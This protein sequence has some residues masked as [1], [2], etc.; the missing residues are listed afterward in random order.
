MSAGSSSIADF[1]EATRRF[2]RD[3]AR[4]IDVDSHHSFVVTFVSLCFDVDDDDDEDRS[5]IVTVAV[6]VVVASRC[7]CCSAA[8]VDS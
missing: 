7:R 4:A 5:M 3:L 6:A 2:S 8:A 1:Q